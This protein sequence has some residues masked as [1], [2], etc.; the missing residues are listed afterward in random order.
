MKSCLDNPLVAIARAREARYPKAPPFHPPERYAELGWLPEFEPNAT[1]H[2]YGAVRAALGMVYGAPTGP[3]WNPL[4]GLVQPGDTV[5]L[6]PNFI[7]EHHEYRR[8]EWQQVITHGAVVRAVCD[9]VLKALEG[10]GRIVVCDAP[11]TDSSFH[12]ICDV[13]GVAALREWYATWSTVPIELVDLRN[14]EWTAKD[15]VIVERRKLEGD[16]DG[17]VP[18]DLGK[19]SEFYGMVP[20][21]GFYGA[22]YQDAVTQEHHRGETHEYLL[23]GTVMKADVVIN[24]PKLKTHKKTGITCALKNLVGINGDKNWLPHYMLGTPEEGG[25]QFPERTIR[26]A[27]ERTMMTWF[28]RR[29][30]HAPTWVNHLF[31]PVKGLG[32]LVFGTT[33]RVVRSGNWHGNDTTW[34]MALDLNTCF[35]YWR[36][37]ALDARHTRRYLCVADG[38][39]GGEGEGPLAPD[40][41]RSGVIVAGESPVAVDTTV[42]WLMGYEW[43]KLKIV[44]GAYERREYPLTSFGPSS[45]KVVSNRREWGGMLEELDGKAALRFKPHFGWMGAIERW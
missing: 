43:R 11:Q 37:G 42:A 13:A 15:E 21:H 9:Y 34:R 26:T 20:P 25:D 23:S 36:A 27:T 10:R 14:E 6:K 22:D 7:K 24:L 31:R 45:V 12:A 19:A 32:K 33:D 28:K 5:I 16:P 4:A 41:V 1:N 30:Y 18:V 39:V 40:A 2:V 8:D 29:L 17:C 35:F 44:A 38:I 3:D